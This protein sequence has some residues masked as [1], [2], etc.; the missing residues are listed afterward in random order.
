MSSRRIDTAEVAGIIRRELK[1]KWPTQQF[2][3]RSRRYS[4]G[5]SI[6]VSWTDGPPEKAVDAVVQNF[7]GADFDSMVDLKSYHNSL[8]QG[9]SVH[10]GADFVFTNRS[11]SPEGEAVVKAKIMA[12]W[13]IDW[14]HDINITI[15]WDE[16]QR[17]FGGGD[18]WRLWSEA[19]EVTDFTRRK[20][21]A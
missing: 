20:L 16:W 4:G 5:S 2:S 13:G 8:Y 21:A 15:G 7:A 14:S 10:F 1:A 9:E 3:V 6:D 12:K 18:P 11:F 17:R 19:A